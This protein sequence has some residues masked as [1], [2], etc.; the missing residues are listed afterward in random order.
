MSHLILASSG[1]PE[2][3]RRRFETEIG[4]GYEVLYLPPDPCLPAP[5]APHPDMI[6][7]VLGDSVVMPEEYLE[8]YP[9]IAARIK[10]T[11]GREPVGSRMRRGP[12][13]PDDIALNCAAAGS[14]LFCLYS[15]AAPE[16]KELA[17]SRGLRPVNVNQ[18]YAACSCLT[19]DGFFITADPSLAAAADAE[20]LD[21]LFITE[22]GISLP[23]YGAGFIG[24]ASGV[25]GN[26]V[27]FFGDL[28]SPPDG[29]AIAKRVEDAGCR[30]VC[31]GN[32]PLFDLGGLKTV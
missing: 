18:G 3:M 9:E 26:R 12:R 27:F 20:G 19:G 14:V 16:I 2:E 24:G 25:I 1:M 22:G 31:L 30:Y 32:G 15:H 10:E 8:T 13:Y 23:G 28:Y 6:A 7:F 17:S 5:V 29:E 11:T 4:E 21:P